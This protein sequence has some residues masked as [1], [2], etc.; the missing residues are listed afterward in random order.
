[1]P[2][3]RVVLH[4]SVDDAQVVEQLGQEYLKDIQQT[5]D[6]D[7]YL[8]LYIEHELGWAE[9]SFRRV[10]VEEIKLFRPRAK[11]AQTKPKLRRA[12]KQGAEIT[13]YIIGGKK[14]A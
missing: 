1:M 7:D 3:Y 5:A 6:D 8:A 14:S 13:S 11:R 4:V 10:L 9:H 2:T 12:K